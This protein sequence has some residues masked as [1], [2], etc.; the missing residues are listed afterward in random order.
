VFQKGNQLVISLFCDIFNGIHPVE[1]LL[2]ANLDIISKMKGRG[3]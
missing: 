3:K 1:A 2:S